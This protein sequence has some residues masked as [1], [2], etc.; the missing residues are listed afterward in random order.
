MGEQKQQPNVT[1]L[2]FSCWFIISYDLLFMNRLTLF[3]RMWN[4][5]HDISRVTI[6]FSKKIG[7]STFFQKFSYIFKKIFKKFLW[8]SSKKN[9]TSFFLGIKIWNRDN[10]DKLPKSGTKAGRSKNRDSR[11]KSGTLPPKSAQLVTLCMKSFI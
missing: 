2:T 7:T 5:D 1:Y 3:K 11:W 8:K 6:F 10:R 4:V 9:F